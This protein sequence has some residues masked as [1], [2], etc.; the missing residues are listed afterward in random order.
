MMTVFIHVDFYI[1]YMYQAVIWYQVV[2]TLICSMFIYN[3]RKLRDPNS[4]T[5]YRQ[6][7]GITY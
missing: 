6:A 5:W 4:R 3:R 7:G 2:N 1:I